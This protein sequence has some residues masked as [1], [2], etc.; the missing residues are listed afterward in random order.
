MCVQEAAELQTDC[1][2]FLLY[3]K[4]GRTSALTVKEEPTCPE[5]LILCCLYCAPGKR[6]INWKSEERGGTR[7]PSTEEVVSWVIDEQS[8]PSAYCGDANLTR[9]T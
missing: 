5:Q 1:F 8:S 4:P 6:E 2:A 7:C 9:E 3:L